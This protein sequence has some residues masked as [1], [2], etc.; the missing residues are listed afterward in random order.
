MI[1]TEI[2]AFFKAID[3]TTEVRQTG[4]NCFRSGTLLVKAQTNRECHICIDGALS[5]RPQVVKEAIEKLMLNFKENKRFDSL[6]I[7]VPLPAK[8]DIF[9]LA[10]SDFEIGNSGKSD[11]IYDQTNNKIKLWIWLSDKECS[12]TKKKS[13]EILHQVVVIDELARKVLLVIKNEKN[14]WVLPVNF[15]IH[16]EELLHKEA[17]RTAQEQGGFKLVA[18]DDLDTELVASI[19]YSPRPLIEQIWAYRIDGVSQKKL[20]P[21]VGSIKK[22]EWVDFDLVPQNGDPIQGVPVDQ[23]VGFYLDN[24]LK[25]NTFSSLLGASSNSGYQA[26]LYK[27]E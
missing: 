10:P 4:Q 18:T 3:E 12:I 24:V 9:G 17:L 6:W 15:S 2:Q 13:F 21:P 19:E 25:R 8:V 14:E 22:A 11:L 7:N 16:Q 23:L 20:N 26:F 5:W 1:P 27:V